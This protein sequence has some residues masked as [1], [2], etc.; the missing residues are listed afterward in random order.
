M[1]SSV[2]KSMKQRELIH[3]RTT[4]DVDQNGTLRHE[5]QFTL[6]DEPR[7]SSVSGS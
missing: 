5:R 3:D 1:Q 6:A 4:A 7:V 2:A